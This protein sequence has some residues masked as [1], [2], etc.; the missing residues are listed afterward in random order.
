MDRVS[1]TTSKLL[2]HSF[3]PHPVGIVIGLRI[4]EAKVTGGGNGT[5]LL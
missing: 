3:I 5:P 4:P 2:S 1:S